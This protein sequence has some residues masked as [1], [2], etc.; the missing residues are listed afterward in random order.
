MVGGSTMVKQ[1]GMGSSLV[2]GRVTVFPTLIPHR[3]K[4]WKIF[5]QRVK[6]F[7]NCTYTV[8]QANNNGTVHLIMGVLR[9][10]VNIS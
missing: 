10:I 7:L 2:G 5:Y 9:K 8:Q 6:Y 4:H 1:L 3:I